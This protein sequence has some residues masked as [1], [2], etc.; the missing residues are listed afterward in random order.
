ML[1]WMFLCILVHISQTTGAV[2]L[3]LGQR[4]HLLSLNIDMQNKTLKLNVNA[5]ITLHTNIVFNAIVLNFLVM[6][7]SHSLW[8]PGLQCSTDVQIGPNFIVDCSPAPWYKVSPHKFQPNLI[9]DPF[10]TISCKTTP[11]HC[12]EHLFFGNVMCL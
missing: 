6:L 9:F 8:C 12:S 2:R 11:K 10:E 3:K 4:M 7:I 5:F 1:F